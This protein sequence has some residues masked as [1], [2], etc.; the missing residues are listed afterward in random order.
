MIYFDNAATTKI[1][2]EILE[3]IIP[4]FSIHYANPSSNH[5]LGKE[6][7]KVIKK[8]K[9]Q[10]SNFLQCNENQ[11]TFTS[12]STESINTI[13]KGMFFSCL[14]KG[15]HIITVKT[16]HKAVLETCKYLETIGA[17]I[18]YLDVDENGLIDLI[19]LEN[20]IK[21]NTILTCVMHANN[22]TGIIQDIDTI[23]KICKKH[24][25]DFFVDATQSIG[26]IPIN[27]ENIDFLCFSGHKIHAPKGIGVLYTKEYSKISP[28]LH[29]G[30]QELIR[31]GTLNT[32][33]IVGIGMACELLLS[34]EFK[35]INDLKLYLE[36]EL[37]T[38]TNILIHGK[39][40]ERISTI[41]NI[42]FYDFEEGLLI[43]KLK[44]FAISQASACNSSVIQPSYVLKA[45]NL[46]NEQS[47]RSIRISV[48]KFT[49][50]KEIDV[51][52]S[53]FSKK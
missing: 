10:I 30:N 5:L 32:P 44:D 4:Y 35:E 31:S 25:I 50:Q 26:K 16:E 19:Q 34:T 8:S 23:G 48:S 3:A 28:L 1:D 33:G 38:L 7:K 17:E 24:T 6:L 21:K 2:D 20:S 52:L 11:I 13:L 49:T 46:T 43:E 41:S 37:Q 12:G 27:L 9:H 53:I 51:F 15:N 36:K 40:V 42:C 18:T 39:N 22:E 45:M 47:F 29:G 14:E